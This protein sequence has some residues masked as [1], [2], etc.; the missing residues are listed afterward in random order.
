MYQKNEIWPL[1]NMR[2][3]WLYFKY[4]LNFLVSLKLKFIILQFLV[5]FKATCVYKNNI[6]FISITMFD[7]SGYG[8]NYNI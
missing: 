5:I 2:R 6:Y 1:I 3:M 8:I 7:E 4:Y